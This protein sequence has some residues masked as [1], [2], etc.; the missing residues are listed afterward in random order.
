MSSK[1]CNAFVIVGD[2]AEPKHYVV[3]PSCRWP[4]ALRRTW[5]IKTLQKEKL[6]RVSLSETQAAKIQVWLIRNDDEVVAF[7]HNGDGQ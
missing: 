2:V 7:G 1:L 4:H 5:K 6:S 3:A